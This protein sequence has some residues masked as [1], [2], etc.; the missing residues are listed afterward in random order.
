M[1]KN[2]QIL[3]YQQIKGILTNKENKD[4]LDFLHNSRISLN[5]LRFKMQ[6]TGIGSKVFIISDNGEELKDIT[7]YGS[8]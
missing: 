7:D 1:N 3:N 5:Y 4:L 8:W 2:I 6:S